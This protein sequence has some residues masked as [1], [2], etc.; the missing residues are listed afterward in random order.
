MT[1]GTSDEGNGRPALEWIVGI[2]SAMAVCAIIGFLAYEAMFGDTQPP[3]LIATVD[4]LENVEGGTLVFVALA[5]RGDQAAAG[6]IVEATIG[7]GDAAVSR[8][9]TFDYVPSRAVERGAFM[10]EQGEVAARDVRLTVHGF[11]EP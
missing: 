7:T 9:L 8:E 10:I 3:A 11:V 5:N 6:V 2:L 1:K 4:G